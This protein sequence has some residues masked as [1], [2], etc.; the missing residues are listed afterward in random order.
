MIKPLTEEVLRQSLHEKCA[1]M[2]RF[3][4]GRKPRGTSNGTNDPKINKNSLQC[5]VIL[6]DGTDLTVELSVSWVRRER[7]YLW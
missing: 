2:F 4:S 7:K 5:R 1:K 3:L 6:L